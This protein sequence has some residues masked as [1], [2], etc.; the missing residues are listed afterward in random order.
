[1]ADQDYRFADVLKDKPIFQ[2]S[3]DLKAYSINY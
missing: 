3:N 1:M 2:I